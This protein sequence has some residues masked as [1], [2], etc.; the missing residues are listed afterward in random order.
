MSIAQQLYEGIDIKKHGTVGLITYMRTDSVR[1]STEAQE[2]A[3]NYIGSTYGDKYVPNTPKVYKGK[4]N[5]QDAHEAIRP[6]DVTLSPD[7]IKDSLKPEQYKLYKLIWQRFLASQME[8]A[9]FDSV[10]VSI[11][12]GKYD[13]KASG[14]KIKFDGF[15]KLYEYNEGEDEGTL[16]PDV[17]E[18]EE[19]KK[20]EIKPEQHFTSP[21]PRYTEASFVKTLEELGIGRP[22]TYA[23]TISTILARNYVEREKKNLYPTEL[24]IIVN[25]IMTDYFKD[26]VNVKYTANME[27]RLDSIEE[28]KEEWKKIVKDFYTPLKKDID[29]AEKEVSKIT[30]EDEVTDEICPLCGKNLVVKR[31]RFGKFLA[32]PDYPE[33]KFTKPIV[34]KL[35][36]KC[37]KC[38]EG[39]VVAKKS[40]KGNKFFG[41]SRFPEC[42][43]VSWYEPTNHICD[44]CGSYM[45]KRFTKAKGSYLECSNPE[46]KAIKPLDNEANDKE[47]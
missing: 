20:S 7:S 26:V 1:I 21:P 23:P 43:F 38:H 17:N 35:D 40:K 4:K 25:Q 6:S 5:I 41:C 29:N 47:E 45:N 15:M 16:I 27:E 19:L 9:V 31:G 24:G 37:P 18:G 11:K 3:L 13:L 12:N 33:C 46:C 22:S 10:S 36:V 39:D 34:E 14:S 28:G 42:D 44:K 30:I 8:S 32:C 2:A